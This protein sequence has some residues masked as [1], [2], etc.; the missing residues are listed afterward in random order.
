[1]LGL[2]K[3]LFRKDDD[4]HPFER[5]LF[6]EV[7]SF[8]SRESGVMLQRQIDMINRMHRSSDGRE[9]RFSSVRH[10]QR[11]FDDRLRF[12]VAAN[13]SLLASARLGMPGKR[14]KLKAE[15]W[16]ENGRVALLRYDRSPEHFFSGEDLRA[17]HPDFSEVKIW[18]DPMQ[19]PSFSAGRAVEI[20]ALTGWLHEWHA[21][22][23]VSNLQPPLPQT[24]RAAHLSRIHADLPREYLDLVSQ[25]EGARIRSC[26]VYGIG[27]IRQISWPDASY[28]ILAEKVGIGALAVRKGGSGLQLLHYEDGEA[29][30]AGHSFQHALVSLLKLGG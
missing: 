11:H 19:V 18:F 16:L 30:S 6:E 13:E 14:R 26:L 9:L 4:F 29:T 28:Y 20:S 25:T 17:V 2:L 1:M 3:S 5:T 10:G 7:K 8:L 21:K 24:R 23:W 12:P 22:G 15:I 27:A